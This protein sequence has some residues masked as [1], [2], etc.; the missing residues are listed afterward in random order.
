MT[1]V[2][3]GRA[4]A[5]RQSEVHRR[6]ADLDLLV[7]WAEGR[8]ALDV[9]TGGGHTAQR[10]RAAGFSVVTADPAPGM[11]PDVICRAEDL[12]FAE[13]SFDTVCCR[14]AAH[15]FD[16]VLAATREMARVARGIV[17]VD[18]L[19]FDGDGAED[20]HRIRDP[21]HVRSYRESEWR[22]L[23]AAAGLEVEAVELFERRAIPYEPWLERT[24]CRGD[25]AARVTELLGDRIVDGRVRMA[26]IL[27][28]GRKR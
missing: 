13:G 8:T 21:S 6:G 14:I 2:W 12:P 1:D 18:D 16:D 5:F 19:L 28:K 26:L 22:E 15:H 7:S 23:F 3:S 27:I 11:R 9:A 4:D 17:L 20:A 24:D 25:E 10:L